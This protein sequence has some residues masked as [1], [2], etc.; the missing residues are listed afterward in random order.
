MVFF[1]AIKTIDNVS[2]SVLFDDNLQAEWLH[3]VNYL[4]HVYLA[5][6]RPDFIA[7]GILG[8]FV[9]GHINPL[10]PAGLREGIKLHRHIDSYTDS[11]PLL[12][13]AKSKFSPVFRRF[14][15]IIIDVMFDHYL[16]RS[17]SSFSDI[18]L[19]Y[20]LRPVYSSLRLY[21]QFFDGRGRQVVSSLIEN[22]WLCEYQ[23]IEMISISLN[24]I[25]R[26]ARRPNPLSR[27]DAEVMC[28]Y[29]YMLEVFNRVF[30]EIISHFRTITLNTS[31]NLV[32]QA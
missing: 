9:R 10:W 32:R 4:A 12:V 24:S 6:P 5:G 8:D 16:V 3:G 22:E 29:D 14:A 2:R 11:H 25:S 19:P 13:A 18:S 21:Q 27:A 30:P 17:W 23:E 20:Y 7:G 31:S 26:R 1:P 28:M 15:G